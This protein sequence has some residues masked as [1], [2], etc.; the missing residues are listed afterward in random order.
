MMWRKIFHRNLV[1]T[2]QIRQQKE[3]CLHK[4]VAQCNGNG[5]VGWNGWCWRQCSHCTCFGGTDF[6]PALIWSQGAIPW[7]AASCTGAGYASGLLR[8]VMGAWLVWALMVLPPRSAQFRHLKFLVGA[9]PGFSSVCR[10]SRGCWFTACFFW[11]SLSVSARAGYTVNIK[12]FQL[13]FLLGVVF[14]ISR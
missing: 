8:R 12:S 2:K 3:P 6:R 4:Q 14:F 7:C 11:I 5:F 10:A 13:K 1:P 9:W